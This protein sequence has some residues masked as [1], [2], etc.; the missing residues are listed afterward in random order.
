MLGPTDLLPLDLWIVVAPFVRPLYHCGARWLGGPSVHGFG[1]F[2]YFCDFLSFDDAGIT[3]GIPYPGKRECTLAD[4][5]IFL[6]ET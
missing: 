4:K 6:M 1:E 5:H 3:S 2:E